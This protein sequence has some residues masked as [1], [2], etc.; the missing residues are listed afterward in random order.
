MAEEVDPFAETTAEEAETAKAAAEA[1]AKKPKKVHVAKSMVTLA[2]KPVDDTVDLNA[3]EAKIRAI[4]KPGLVWG[5]AEKRELCYGIFQLSIGA[6][7]TD[8][9]SVDELQEEIEGWDD[10]VQSV[11]CTEF[12]NC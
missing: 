10:L 2:V 7:M 12:Q 8:D 6:V 3:V 11:D 1:A 4:T 9:I 5:K